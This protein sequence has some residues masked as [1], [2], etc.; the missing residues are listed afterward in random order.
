MKDLSPVVEKTAEVVNTLLFCSDVFPRYAG[1]VGGH[2]VKVVSDPFVVE[3]DALIGLPM[4]HCLLMV[5]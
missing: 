2:S 5:W 3:Y 4:K 1:V